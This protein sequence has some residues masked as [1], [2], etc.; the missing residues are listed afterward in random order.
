MVNF[1]SDRLAPATE[2]PTA[3]TAASAAVDLKKTK[4]RSMGHPCSKLFTKITKPTRS[5]SKRAGRLNSENGLSIVGL[6][7][8]CGARLGKLRPV[9]R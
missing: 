8:C 2:N 3:D 6:Q 9:A 5:S 1:L 4:R 7:D